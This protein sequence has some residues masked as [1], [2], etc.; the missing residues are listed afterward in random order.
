MV[1]ILVLKW[2][3]LGFVKNCGRNARA[4]EISEHNVKHS[5]HQ[6]CIEASW[7]VEYIS[8]RETNVKEMK[9]K[10]KVKMRLSQSWLNLTAKGRY[11]FWISY[12]VLHI[13][14]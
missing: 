13:S 12:P 8:G 2:R 11:L 9:L 14:L 6:A 3:G 7:C 5:I 1:S 4:V 10:M